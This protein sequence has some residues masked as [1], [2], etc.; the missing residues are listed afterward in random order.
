MSAKE[1]L[2]NENLEP[3]NEDRGNN[4]SPDLPASDPW[5]TVDPASKQARN[6]S[7]DS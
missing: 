1:E 6:H 4:S 3:E 7:S 5:E 2:G